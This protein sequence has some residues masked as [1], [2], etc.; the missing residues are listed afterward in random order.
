MSVWHQRARKK[1]FMWGKT[2]MKLQLKI[3][4]HDKESAR[5]CQTAKSARNIKQSWRS[6]F[7]HNRN[8]NSLEE[9]KNRHV[10][11]QISKHLHNH[12]QGNKPS[13][14]GRAESWGPPEGGAHFPKPS[15]SAISS[16]SSHKHT[17]SCSV[18]LLR[19]FSLSD[20]PTLTSKE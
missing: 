10:K 16:S 6:F 20:I 9:P 7:L 8:K 3:S 1:T 5:S 15:T 17:R 19:N 13:S 18:L 14:E 11:K 12:P 4:R 2:L